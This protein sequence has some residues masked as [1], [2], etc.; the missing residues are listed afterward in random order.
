MTITQMRQNRDCL[1]ACLATVLQITWE[2]AAK[3]LMHFDLK[4]PLTSLLFSTHWWLRFTLWR[5]G[6]KYRLHTTF[7]PEQWV[8]GKTIVLVHAQGNFLQRLISKHWIVY[9]G[10]DYGTTA[11]YWGD[12][13]I[14]VRHLNSKAREL[15][16][17]WPQLAITIQEN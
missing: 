11:F 12:S 16:E 9:A 5:H 6:I 8:A 14:A 3:L 15:F 13:D 10:Q 1:V 17:A 2:Q 4:S 7:E